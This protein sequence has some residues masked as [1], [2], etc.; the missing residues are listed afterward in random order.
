MVRRDGER[1]REKGEREKRS[2]RQG[3]VVLLFVA[4]ISFPMLAVPE[5]GWKQALY[6]FGVWGAA[7]AATAAVSRGE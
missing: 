7:A 4:A 1:E 6:L 3:G 5:K 2:A